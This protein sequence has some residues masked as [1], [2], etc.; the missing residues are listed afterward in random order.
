MI[1]GLTGTIGSGKSAVA[2]MMEALGAVIADTDD[3]ARQVVEPHTCGWEKIVECWGRGILAPDMSIDRKKLASIVFHNESDRIKL[4]GIIHPLIA[5]E[6]AKRIASAPPGRHVVLVVPLL[7]ES[8]FDKMTQSNWVVAA[9]ESILIDRITSRDS[10]AKE[11]A[12]AR[13]AAQMPQEDK[14]K[15]ADIVIWN[16]GSLE[17]T[18]EQVTQAWKKYETL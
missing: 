13:I 18:R 8:G 17:E 14:I 10:C 3:I 2:S 6:T 4:N 5:A 12:L 16:N 15:R 9:N 11:D 7:F 1:I